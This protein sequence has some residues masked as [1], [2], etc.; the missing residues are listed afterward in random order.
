MRVRSLPVAVAVFA[1]AVPEDAMTLLCHCFVTYSLVTKQR[2]GFIASVQG[3]LSALPLILKARLESKQ[4]ETVCVQS[5]LPFL[6]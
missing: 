2:D 6:R 5:P 3:V 1:P 4:Q